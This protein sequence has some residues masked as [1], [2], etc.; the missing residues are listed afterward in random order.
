[1]ETASLQSLLYHL[2]ELMLDSQR[3]K[4]ITMVKEAMAQVLHPFLLKKQAFNFF[5]ILLIC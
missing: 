4:V 2:V 1:M 3:S 5:T